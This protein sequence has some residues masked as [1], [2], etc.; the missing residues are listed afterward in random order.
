MAIVEYT[1]YRFNPSPLLDHEYVQLK[2]YLTLHP[3]ADDLFPILKLKE[4][5]ISVHKTHLRAITYFILFS[6]LLAIFGMIFD[7]F[8]AV[9]GLLI[10]SFILMSGFSNIMSARCLISYLMIR[11]KYYRK[12]QK[13]IIRSTDYQHFMQIRKPWI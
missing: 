11:N 6:I 3:E 13:D 4:Q 10:L 2:Q 7:E 9:M 1:D 8:W 5:L 12:L